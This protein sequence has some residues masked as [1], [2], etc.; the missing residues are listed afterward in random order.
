MA[1]GEGELEIHVP[2]DIESAQP[3]D[4]ARAYGHGLSTREQVIAVV[5]DRL[6]AGGEGSVRIDDVHD[7]FGVSIGSS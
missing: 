2:D 5:V 4:E 6:E 3:S 7:R 1:S